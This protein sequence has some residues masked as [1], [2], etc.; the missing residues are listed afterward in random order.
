MYS[1]VQV[2][3]L[4]AFNFNDIWGS[5]SDDGGVTWSAPVNYTNTTD[6]DEMY[7]SISKTGNTTTK[8]HIVYQSTAGPGCQSF[9]DNTPVYRVY[10]VYQKINPVTGNVINVKNI[11]SEVPSAFSLKQNYPNPFNPT[12]SI[13]FEIAKTTN[14]TLKVYDINGREM[15]I[16]VNGELVS[17]GLKEAVFDGKNFASGVYFYTL[18]AGDFTATKKMI[19]I[20]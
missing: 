10:E 17:P 11:S 14:V 12:T 16:L 4:D 18:Q 2:D 5:Y 15:A 19:L 13:R 6:V 9:T 1:G 20:K 3:T 7:P 8:I